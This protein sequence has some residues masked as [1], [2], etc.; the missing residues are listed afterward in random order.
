MNW[1]TSHQSPKP[2]LTAASMHEFSMLILKFLGLQLFTVVF[3]TT[4]YRWAGQH[5]L[6]DLQYALFATTILTELVIDRFF[7]SKI[8]FR[9]R[10]LD[11]YPEAEMPG[12]FHVGL[13]T[14][15]PLFFIPVV[16]HLATTPRKPHQSIPWLYSNNRLATGFLFAANVFTLVFANTSLPSAAHV[17]SPS[18]SYVSKISSTVTNSLQSAKQM[19]KAAINGQKPVF[20]SYWQQGDLNSTKMVLGLAAY[21]GAIE[22]YQSRLPANEVESYRTS[23]LQD[24]IPYFSHWNSNRSPWADIS[25]ISLV[26]PA[27]LV[28]ASMLALTD[29]V[30]SDTVASGVVTKIEAIF[31]KEPNSAQLMQGLRESPISKSAQTSQQSHLIQYLNRFKSE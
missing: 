11:L 7:K 9:R 28:E 4:A 29:M 6:R 1:I 16:A 15:T 3:V 30:V 13:L 14:W 27:A 2:S 21:F 12:T 31:N 22:K 17:L 19:K 10:W 24:L 18:M 26:T 5:Q 23:A 25:V 8:D 20:G